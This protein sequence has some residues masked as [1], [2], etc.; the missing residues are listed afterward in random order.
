MLKCKPNRINPKSRDVVLIA[1][2]FICGCSQ[3]TLQQKIDA[4]ALQ[5]TIEVNNSTALPE[6]LL[7]HAFTETGYGDYHHNVSRQTE[8]FSTQEEGFV[9]QALSYD[10]SNRTTVWT[11][12]RYGELTLLPGEHYQQAGQKCRKFI[13]SYFQT[14]TFITRQQQMGSACF[15]PVTQKWTWS[16]I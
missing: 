10:P 8:N 14:A 13:V 4:L 1:L 12:R 2:V 16:D 5:N 9:Q 3:Q 6:T 11:N 15:N 7:A